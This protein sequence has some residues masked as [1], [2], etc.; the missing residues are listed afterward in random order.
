MELTQAMSRSFW[1]SWQV[2]I[3]VVPKHGTCEFQRF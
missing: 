1:M 2:W 3:M